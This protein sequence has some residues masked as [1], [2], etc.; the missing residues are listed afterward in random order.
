MSNELLDP[1]SL[2]REDVNRVLRKLQRLF[3]LDEDGE[4]QEYWNPNKELGQEAVDVT[5]AILRAAKLSPPNVK[6]GDK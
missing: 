6:L 5:I 4:G 1:A 3:W 2:P